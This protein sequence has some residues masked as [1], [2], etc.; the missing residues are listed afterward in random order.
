MKKMYNENMLIFRQDSF[1]HILLQV[2]E[3]LLLCGK[4]ETLTT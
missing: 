4:Y 3:N 2:S 1:A